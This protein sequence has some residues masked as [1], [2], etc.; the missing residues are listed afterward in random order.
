M[1]FTECLQFYEWVKTFNPDATGLKEF[2]KL[3][4]IP[5]THIDRLSPA[6]VITEEQNEGYY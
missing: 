3:R 4:P 5:Q 1:D 6:G 2:H